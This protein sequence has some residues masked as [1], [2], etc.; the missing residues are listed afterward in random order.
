MSAKSPMS[1]FT[2]Y[3]T[4]L[5]QVDNL[6]QAVAHIAMEPVS[7]GLVEHLVKDLVSQVS[8]LRGEGLQVS[9]ATAPVLQRYLYES[10]EISDLVAVSNLAV[11]SRAPFSLEGC[12]E[13]EQIKRNATASANGKQVRQIVVVG[14]W[15]DLAL[16]GA[17]VLAIQSLLSAKAE[18]R[19]LE[20]NSSTNNVTGSFTLFSTA[21]SPRAMFKHRPD[22]MAGEAPVLSLT[23]SESELLESSRLA[24]ALWQDASAFDVRKL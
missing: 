15:L 2:D 4:L 10:P 23:T 3:E 12:F 13:G 5:G 24:T 21:T 8:R 7:M 1:H 19:V 6:K 14:D 11:T 16:D 9:D 20:L 18:V 17:L 22:A